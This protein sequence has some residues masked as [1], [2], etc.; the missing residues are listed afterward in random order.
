M[1]TAVITVV[2]T[3]SEGI[4]HQEIVEAQTIDALEKKLK[5]IL[6]QLVKDFHDDSDFLVEED[7]D[8]C[9][10]VAEDMIDEEVYSPSCYVGSG[11]IQV[12]F[13]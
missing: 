9:K 13:F 8:H 12:K 4:D 2:V 11:F 10:N 7:A 1:K 5:K 3:D 6:P